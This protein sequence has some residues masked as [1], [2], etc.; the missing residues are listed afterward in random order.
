MKGI[1][2]MVAAGALAWGLGTG[3]APAAEK[4]AAVDAGKVL[5]A[6][7]KTKEADAKMEELVT[8]ARAERE[9]MLAELKK[10]KKEFEDARAEAQNKALSEKAVNEKKDLAEE[11]LTQVVEYE[12][13]IRETLTLRQQQLEEQQFRIHQ[14]LVEEISA[15][16]GR[17]AAQEGYTLVLDSSGLTTSGFREVVWCVSNLDITASVIEALNKEKPKKAE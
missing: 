9:K 17:F 15:A 6:F 8:E 16:I 13:K 14:R 10:L 11:K 4:I 5:K 12:N 7:G 1:M 3:A 2:R